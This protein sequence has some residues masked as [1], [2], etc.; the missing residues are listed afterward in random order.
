MVQAEK[1]VKGT[2]KRTQTIKV[3]DICQKLQR[4]TGWNVSKSSVT[5]IREKY[6]MKCS[7][8]VSSFNGHL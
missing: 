2:C 8:F 6:V 1:I 5:R 7:F 3:N 4:K